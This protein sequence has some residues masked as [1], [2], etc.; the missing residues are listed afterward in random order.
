MKYFTDAGTTIMDGETV[1]N[2]F[3]ARSIEKVT[4]DMLIDYIIENSATPE[5]VAAVLYNDEYYYW[6]LL[7]LNNCI[8]PILDWVMSDDELLIYGQ[9]KYGTE[10]GKLHHYE[11]NGETVYVIDELLLKHYK[12]ITNSDYLEFENEKKRTIKII[13]KQHLRVL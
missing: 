2:I 11:Y 8:D 3:E 4:D 5:Q 1:C 9:N 10:L 13:S 7:A 12:T 6:V